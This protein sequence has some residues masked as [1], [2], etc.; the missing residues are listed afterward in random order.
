MWTSV[1]RDEPSAVRVKLKKGTGGAGGGG[2]G[3]VSMRKGVNG[4]MRCLDG[5][6]RDDVKSDVEREYDGVEEMGDSEDGECEKY[7]SSESYGSSSESLGGEGGAG[8]FTTV[9][10]P[11]NATSLIILRDHW[12]AAASAR[13]THVRSESSMWTCPAWGECDLLRA[14]G[15]GPLS[16]GELARVRTAGV[17]EDGEEEPV[18]YSENPASE[19][20]VRASCSLASLTKMKSLMYEDW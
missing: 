5:G 8:C 19:N 15:S 4:V 11:G 14:A 16:V 7:P 10:S 17:G 3:V 20:K 9:M 2:N 18:E 1:V 13:P 12:S 6:F